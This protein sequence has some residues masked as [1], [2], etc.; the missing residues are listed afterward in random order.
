[1]RSSSDKPATVPASRTLV[2]F[3]IAT[4]TAN[5]ILAGRV[6][7]EQ[8][9]LT[10]REGPQMVGFALAHGLWFPLIT[11]PVLLLLLAVWLAMVVAQGLACGRR[12]GRKLA[13]L[14]SAT[15]AV[16]AALLTPYQVWQRTFA[17]RLMHGPYAGEF[18]DEAAAV[19]DRATV[20]AFLAHGGATDLTDRDG[21]TPLHAAAVGN[22]PEMIEFL[23]ARGAALNAI[24][25]FGDSP[26]Q[27]ALGNDAQDAARQL[28]A[29]GAQRV[30]GTKQQF[31]RVVAEDVAQDIARTSRARPTPAR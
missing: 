21:K 5:A 23:V 15:I 16:G 29:Y 26:L 27:S 31:D 7:W 11:S 14:A 4:L 24:D 9:A 6:V 18:M 3:G 20:A 30:Q 12:P 19:G 25:R 17:T 28:K 22:Q 13:S 1:M 2:L 8:T 10:W